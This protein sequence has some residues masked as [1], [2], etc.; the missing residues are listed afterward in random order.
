MNTHHYIDFQAEGKNAES[1]E[2]EVQKVAKAYFGK[3]KFE[4][5][6]IHAEVQTRVDYG[7]PVTWSARC[8]VQLADPPAKK[9]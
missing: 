5:L 2:V 3:R 7:E 1:I 8:V 4:I 9:H 6:E